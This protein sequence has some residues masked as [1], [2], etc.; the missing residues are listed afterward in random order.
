MIDSEFEYPEIC[1]FCHVSNTFSSQK[2]MCLNCS[3]IIPARCVGSHVFGE[4]RD[5]RDKDFG[6]LLGHIRTCLK[7]GWHEYTNYA[8]SNSPGWAS[9]A[10]YPPDKK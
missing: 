1:P 6:V 8:A 4:K 3:S 7:C 9:V 10:I 2:A 5:V